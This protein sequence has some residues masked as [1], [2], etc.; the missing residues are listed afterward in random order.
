M[1]LQKDIERIDA[2]VINEKIKAINAAN[3]QQR[4][5]LFSKQLEDELAQDVD[6]LTT[7]G[8]K[9][10]TACMERFSNLSAEN[11]K[12]IRSFRPIDAITDFDSKI[13]RLGCTVEKAKGKPC[14]LCHQK[15]QLKLI[16]EKRAYQTV[17]LIDKNIE[18]TESDLDILFTTEQFLEPLSNQ[19]RLMILLRL[20]EGK[21]SYTKLR[22]ITKLRGGHLTFHLKKLSQAKLI[23]QEDDKGDYIVTWRGLEA[24]K[25]IK[26]FQQ[27]VN[28]EN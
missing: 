18:S 23:A 2:S 12:I 5:L 4:T 6:N 20:S 16:K 24:I 11:I 9:N 22:Q 15:M 25:T 19:I 10:K 28:T 21:K 14:E 3:N 8:C 13:E 27:S 17:V 7:A 26:S 1:D